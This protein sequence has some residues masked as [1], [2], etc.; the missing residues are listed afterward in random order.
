M[1]ALYNEHVFPSF[2][3]QTRSG[4]I[5]AEF[6]KLVSSN[7]MKERSVKFYADLLL[8]TPNHLTETIKTVTGKSAG[9]WIGEI[10]IL[11]VKVLLQDSTLTVSDIANTL[12]FPTNLPLVNSLKT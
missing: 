4:Q 5:A 6:K 12:H 9:A 7:F 3:I 1:L 2:Y 10:I 8:V 11:E